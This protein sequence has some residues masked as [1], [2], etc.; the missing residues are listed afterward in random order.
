MNHSMSYRD[1]STIAL[2]R[3]TGSWQIY[4]GPLTHQGLPLE[5]S[6]CL[7]LCLSDCKSDDLN[8]E[9]NILL[10]TQSPCLWGLQNLV[11]S[12]PLFVLF[13]QKCFTFFFDKWRQLFQHIRTDKNWTFNVIDSHSPLL[14]LWPCQSLDLH[15]G[16]GVSYPVHFSGMGLLA[17]TPN[18]QTLRISDYTLLLTYTG[19]LTASRSRQHSSPDNWGAQTSCPR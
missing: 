2:M 6:L 19:G 14:A 15:I 10:A 16:S 12:L 8:C 11:G 1:C 4:C 7:Q 9:S 3:T 5:I 18:P 17:S 13:P